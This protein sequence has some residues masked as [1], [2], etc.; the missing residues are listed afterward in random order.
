MVNLLK[1]TSFNNFVYK[2]YEGTTIEEQKKR[3]ERLDQGKDEKE[4]EKRAP[5]DVPIYFYHPDHLGTTN[6]LT[7]VNGNMYQFFLNLPFGETMAE[8]TSISYYQTEFKFNG[9]ELDSETGMYYYGARYYNPSL[10]IW[11]SVDPLA[12]EM[13][14]WSP[15]NYTFNN[16][17]RFT[18]PDGRAPEAPEAPEDVIILIGGAYKGHPYG[19]VAIGIIDANG[20]TIVYDFGR[21]R[22]T[23]GTFNESGD[24][25]LRV[26]SSLESY[27]EG[28]NA[29]GRTTSGYRFKSTP[30]EDMKVVEY[31]TGLIEKS[32]DRKTEVK[33]TRWSFKLEDDYHATGNNC[34]TLSLCGLNVALP[35][36]AKELKDPKESKGRGLG[37]KEK[38]AD[39]T[40]G[41]N[42]I[43]NKIFMPADLKKNIDTKNKH[44]DSKQY[45]N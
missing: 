45:S 29:T 8:Q 21:Y 26:H 1:E 28:E 10:S 14:E 13:P 4:I 31:F 12:E 39:N 18:D 32:T 3:Y 16:P 20:N 2:K 41:N 22:A 42:S 36:V 35:D 30:G 23:S 19:H 25:V 11:M 6:A 40:I 24:G 15:Y 37:W 34:T 17:I 43:G 33:D 7:D 5:V 44:I 38:L 9:K 27:I